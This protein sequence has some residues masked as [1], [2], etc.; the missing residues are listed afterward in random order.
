MICQNCTPVELYCCSDT[1][2]I[3][4]T[5]DDQINFLVKIEDVSNGK[6]WI[7]PTSIVYTDKLSIDISEIQFA[8]NHSYELHLLDPD[9]CN[10]SWEINSTS[11]ECLMVRFSKYFGGDNK[12]VE[13]NLE[14]TIKIC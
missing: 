9:M 10:A 3:G 8:E 12:L 14:Q 5:P 13:M 2:V 1:L 6:K 7:L 11:V 4:D